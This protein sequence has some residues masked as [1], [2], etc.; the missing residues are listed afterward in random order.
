MNCRESRALFSAY[1][2]DE[3]TQAEREWLE[4][5]FTSCPSC[6]SEYDD[7]TRTLELMGGL[8][9]VE[10]STGFAESVL[11]RARRKS[12]AQDRVPSYTSRWIPL[13]AI[14]ALVA[15]LGGAALQ[16]VGQP[17]LLHRRSPAEPQ[18][19]MLVEQPVRIG[20]QSPAQGTDPGLLVDAEV[21]MGEIP[22]SLF[23]RSEDVEFILD[24]VTLR[25]GR[26]HTVTPLGPEPA[27][28]AAAVITF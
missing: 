1:W 16:W 9:R 26:A 3:L 11:A 23:D 10:V 12:P 5:H 27:R 22:D 13:T 4:A 20:A 8:P 19:P 25:K 24:A 18:E 17:G 7:L 2:D 14:A 28:G 6:R 15:V 21:G